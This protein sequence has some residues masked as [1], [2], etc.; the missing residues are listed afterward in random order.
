MKL[1]NKWKFEVERTPYDFVEGN[2]VLYSQDYLESYP[3]RAHLIND[4]EIEIVIDW[5]I[6][7]HLEELKSD[8]ADCYYERLGENWD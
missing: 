5:M 8:M 7:E 6:D 3:E 4:W 2:I 1:P